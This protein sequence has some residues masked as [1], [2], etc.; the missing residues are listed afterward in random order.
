MGACPPVTEGVLQ[1]YISWQTMHTT[2]WKLQCQY[3]FLQNETLLPDKALIDNV[4][5]CNI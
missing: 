4:S 3:N 2:G 1:S 5:V